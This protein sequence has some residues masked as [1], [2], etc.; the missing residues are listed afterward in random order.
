MKITVTG[1]G[2]DFSSFGGSS[3]AAL[4]DVSFQIEKGE[5][6]TLLGPS[7]CGKSTTLRCIAG[8]ETPDRGRVTIG[9]KVVAAPGI[10]VPPHQRPIGM[11]FQSYAI[12]PHM[13]VFNNVAFPLTNGER[14][15]SKVE[16]R[17]RVMEMLDLMQM[18]HLADRPAPYLS[19]G[20][21]QRVALARA[22]VSSSE[23]LLLDEPL[24]NLDAKLREDLRV[25]IKELTKRLGIT[26]IYVTHDQVE[27]LAMS[28]RIAVMY[29]GKIVQ[30]A[31][32]YEL[33]TNPINDFVAQFVGRVNLFDGI[34]LEEAAQGKGVVQTAQGTFRCVMAPGLATGARAKLAVRPET[35]SVAQPGQKA[36]ANILDGDVEKVMFLGEAIECTVR[37]QSQPVLAKLP[38]TSLVSVGEHIRLQFSSDTSRLL[39]AIA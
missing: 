16:Y 17:R 25:E 15:V 8:L 7:G 11:V 34:V 33:Y 18:G 23:V 28:D 22:L 26:S 29:G 27:A 6:Y 10:F 39:P 36:D 19:G 1:L 30:E 12:W 31:T 38:I 21:Q 24:S 14:K 32:P 13:T 35:L 20:Q 37:A 4:K 3:V 5:F 9:D 2:K